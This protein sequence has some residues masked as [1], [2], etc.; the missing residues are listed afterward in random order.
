MIRK[1]IGENQRLQAGLAASERKAQG[2]EVAVVQAQ[3]QVT[4]NYDAWVQASAQCESLAKRLAQ[5]PSPTA[6]F[7]SGLIGLGAGAGLV[8][9]RSAD[10][11]E[12]EYEYE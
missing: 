11:D 5:A 2:L 8:S 10:E 1:V 7:L 12:D 6:V 4:V 9:S 3:T